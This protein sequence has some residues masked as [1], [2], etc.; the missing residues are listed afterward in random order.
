MRY[1]TKHTKCNCFNP[2]NKLSHYKSIFRTRFLLFAWNRQLFAASCKLYRSGFSQG[3]PN[4]VITIE[5]NKLVSIRFGIYFVVTNGLLRGQY[6]QFYRKGF[7]LLKGNNL[8]ALQLINCKQQYTYIFWS[9][10]VFIYFTLILT[11]LHQFYYSK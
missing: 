4:E 3:W 9:S 5:Q 8:P 6:K 10:N 1:K 11:V 2:M 7:I